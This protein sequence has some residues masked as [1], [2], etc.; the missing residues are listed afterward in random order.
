MKKTKSKINKAKIKSKKKAVLKRT[1]LILT[2]IFL[3]GIIFVAAVNIYVISKADSYIISEEEAMKIDADCVIAPG[4]LVYADNKLSDILEH[5]V[6]K[7]IELYKNGAA[8]KILMSGDHGRESYNEVKAMKIYAQNDGVP[9]EDIFLD[10]AGFSTYETMYRA[11]D[12]FKAKKVI[13]VTQKFHLSRAVYLARSLGIEAYGVACDIGTYKGEVYNNI[14]E[15]AARVKAVYS[16][17]AKPEPAFLGDAIPIS[18]N[19]IISDD[20]SEIK[21]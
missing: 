15:T 7:A 2:A 13:I 21:S 5:R 11:K 6:I 20:E 16:A 9:V 8:K 19:G 17:I 12:V 4:A 1:A 18:G 3:T 10:H 14:R